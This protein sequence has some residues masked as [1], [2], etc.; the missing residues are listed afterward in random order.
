MGV[1]NNPVG[2]PIREFRERSDNCF[3]RTVL[4][5]HEVSA[6]TDS[7]YLV[8]G[9]IERES[10]VVLYGPPGSGKTFLAL[11]MLRCIATG[12][13][14]F[15]RSVHAGAVLY[16][17]SEGGRSVERRLFG[18]CQERM[19]SRDLTM[20]PM[21]LIPQPIMLNSLNAA[22]EIESIVEAGKSLE[23]WYGKRLQL[24]V[25]DTLSR[26]IPGG[27]ENDAGVMSAVVHN[28]KEMMRE[29]ECG[30]LLVHHSG[31]DQSQGARGHSSLLAAVD[32]EL[33]IK[34]NGLVRD[35]YADKQRDGEE[36]QQLSFKLDRIEIGRDEDGDPVTTCVVVDSGIELDP[37]GKISPAQD[38]V[39]WA[40][41][42]ASQPSFEPTVEPG[43]G[44]ACAGQHP[45]GV[46]RGSSTTVRTVDARDAYL[47]G[48]RTTPDTRPDRKRPT[49]LSIK[50]AFR[51]SVNKLKEMGFIKETG[52]SLTWITR[53]DE[54]EADQDGQG[55]VG[56]QAS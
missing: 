2:M 56:G 40:I 47:S 6:H 26:S 31:K 32:S 55:R 36:G 41:E 25:V 3:V 28:C 24:L 46:S 49:D 30:V 13:L 39:R 35:L 14:F 8:K 9:L 12:E 4:G 48:C 17:A 23:D 37:R 44:P 50:K 16:I 29:L 34:R 52:D 1:A 51:R 21:A 22:Q 27:N 15:D 19:A 7:Q 38:L 43:D 42:K 10:F 54:P 5:I 18:L 20:V 11:E 33:R 53:R 45:R